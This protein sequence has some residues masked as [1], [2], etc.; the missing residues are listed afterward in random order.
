MAEHLLNGYVSIPVVI[1]LEI[2]EIG[3]DGRVELNLALLD[4][5]HNTGGYKWLG[6]RCHMK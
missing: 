5:L 2:R 4:Q 3:D 1:Q 6:D